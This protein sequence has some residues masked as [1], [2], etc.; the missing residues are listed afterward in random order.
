MLKTSNFK[1]IK[2]FIFIK[3]QRQHPRCNHRCG[4]DNL[5]KLI[6]I[7][8]LFSANN[9]VRQKSCRTGGGGSIQFFVHVS[10]VFF[11]FLDTHVMKC[12][13]FFTYKGPSL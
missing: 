3:F 6:N 8:I 13:A 11:F 12:Y 2:L 7:I 1:R 4:G 10:S 5:G 9:N